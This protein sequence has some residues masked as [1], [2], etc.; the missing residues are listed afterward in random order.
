MT[1]KEIAEKA[2]VSIATVSMVLNKKDRRISAKTRQRILTVADELNYQPNA[3]ARSLVTAQTKTIGLIIPDVANPFFAE[4]AKCIETQLSL[5]NYHVFLCNANNDKGKEQNYLSE[6]LGRKIDGL[7]ISSVNADTLLEKNKESLRHTPV[8]IFDRIAQTNDFYSV[9]VEDK[10]G[11]RLAA[12][13]LLRNGHQNFA[14]I[15]GSVNHPNIRARV[16]GF[17]EALAS[18]KREIK[19]MAEGEMTIESSYDCAKKLIPELARQQI[20]ALFCTNDLIALGVYK[21]CKEAGVQ[22]PRDISVIG[23]DNIEYAAYL[24]PPLTTVAQP[25]SEIGDMA[26]AMMLNIIAGNKQYPKHHVLPVH[27][28][29]RDSMRKI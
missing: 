15:S 26:A 27:L 12:E 7:I 29:R 18:Q 5:E 14:C 4:I 9:S 16:D 1:I 23:F 21:A 24:T 13:E 11:G 28:L 25:I 19:W 17:G 8:V 2:N 3:I 22:I 6:L 10:L 20:T